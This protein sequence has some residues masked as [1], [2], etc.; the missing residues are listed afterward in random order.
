MLL[1]IIFSNGDSQQY[2]FTHATLDNDGLIKFFNNEVHF[3]Y[4]D[5]LSYK[6][7]ELGLGEIK[8]DSVEY[9]T[10]LRVYR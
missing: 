7:I 5:P 10:D 8:V 4:Y 1:K 3:F 9:H 6:K 2:T